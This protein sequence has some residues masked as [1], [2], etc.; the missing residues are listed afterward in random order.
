VGQ[1]IQETIM[2][3]TLSRA[4]WAVVLALLLVPAVAPVSAQSQFP[5]ALTS[6]EFEALLPRVGLPDAQ[7]AAAMA[8]YDRYQRAT[9]ELRSGSIERYLKDQPEGGMGNDER[10]ADEV[11]NQ[12]RTYRSLLAQWDTLENALID[13]LGALGTDGTK[14]D[15]VRRALELRRI[16]Q[17]T[18]DA[19]M[20]R[21]GSQADLW[22]ITERS[23]KDLDPS[24][25]MQ[26]EERIGAREAQYVDAV[27]AI[28][29]AALEQP[30]RLIVLRAKA[31]AD[32]PR[33]SAEAMQQQMEQAQEQ[34]A[35]IDP[36]EFSR[37]FEAHFRAMAGAFQQSREPVQ[38]ARTRATRLGA[39]ILSDAFQGIPQPRGASAW[40]AFIRASGMG[41]FGI[42]DGGSIR[43]V[44]SMAAKAPLT[45]EQDQAVAAAFATWQTSVLGALND[46]GPMAFLGDDA[47][48]IQEVFRKRAEAAT[49]RTAALKAGVRAAFGLPP[50][51]EQ[52]VQDEPDGG[53]AAGDAAE[54][55]GV[56]V[57]VGVA[58]A[59]AA[60]TEGAVAV[61]GDAVMLDM[62]GDGLEGLVAGEDGGPMLWQGAGRPTIQPITKQELQ[63]LLDLCGSAES[64]KPVV[65]QLHADYL[66]VA[67][68]VK[69]QLDAAPSAQMSFGPNG[70]TPPSKEDIA[71][72]YEALRTALGAMERAD[73]DFFADL[74]AVVDEACVRQQEQFRAR[75]LARAGCGG[76][77]SSMAFGMMSGNRSG[78]FVDPESVIRAA[79]TDGA[80]DAAAATALRDHVASRGHEPILAALKNQFEVTM[81]K[82]RELALL[83]ADLFK[84]AANGDAGVAMAIDE[85][86][87]QRMQEAGEA[88]GNA[89]SEAAAR[90]RQ[91][92]D[93]LPA[94]L[95]E[96]Q[97]PGFLRAAD[98]VRY[99]ET[100][101]D[102][103]DME[104]MFSK[105]LA[106]DGLDT[107]ATGA[108]TAQRSE[109]RA[110][111]AKLRDQLAEVRPK[112]AMPDFSGADEGGME[113]FQARM[114]ASQAAQR[115]LRQLKTDRDELNRR[116]MRQLQAA[117]GE[118]RAKAIG[119]LPAQRKGRGLSIPGLEGVQITVP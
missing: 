103:T 53:A 61:G 87:S 60:A 33:P 12:V 35:E 9:S 27:R 2:T 78:P 109:Y 117:L 48:N 102:P 13:S 100:F 64:V 11:R 65:T 59:P 99:P 85:S 41:A 1:P 106:L 62:S 111:Y 16:E 110:A 77:G 21:A 29:T 81:S 107:A 118:E 32:H 40:L 71:A 15:R 46:Q 108:I 51:P 112:T 55:V 31:M 72:K 36:G 116:T 92:L 76:A 63:E 97:R 91:V 73:A 115:Q 50:E 88:M 67:S 56:T 119:E 45:P 6:T 23:T 86:A 57:R 25:L 38:A 75:S 5:T 104:P 83:E 66:E 3:Q 39:T 28:R 69:E 98:V 82:G 101:K 7:R 37:G 93:A 89:R 90:A 14:L 105:A 10:P 22:A 68:V 74:A 4:A 34:G 80:I 44:E 47:E 58:I 54:P 70:A 94:L 95:K 8:E 24:Q 18:S 30:E 113:D 52:I 20:M 17:S 43:L 19:F 42:D 96:P 84:P 26:I 114:N 79:V 49:A